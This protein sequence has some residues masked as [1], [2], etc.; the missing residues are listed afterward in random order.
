MFTYI[1]KSSIKLAYKLSSIKG[2]FTS[3]IIKNILAFGLWFSFFLENDI[4]TS[5]DEAVL[6]DLEKDFKIL[7]IFVR[8]GKQNPKI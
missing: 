2:N 7:T 5:T 4:N 3:K 8:N 6:I 1:G